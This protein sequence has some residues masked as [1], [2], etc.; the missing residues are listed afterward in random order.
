[1]FRVFP[2]LE[3]F[4]GVPRYMD[5]CDAL[6]LNLQRA[7]PIKK[8]AAGPAFRQEWRRVEAY[9]ARVMDGVRE[10]WVV[11]EVDRR[12]LLRRRP[13]ANVR[14]IPNGIERRWEDAG[15]AAEKAPAALFLGNLTVGHN[16]DAA[17]HFA[18]EVWPRVR[19]AMPEAE[20]HLVGEP[21]PQVRALDGRD[22][23]RVMGYVEDLRPVLA[24][25]VVSVAP[26]RYGAGIQN[27]VLET[28]AAGLPSLLSGMVAEP[29]GAAPGREVV[30]AD[31]D[32]ATAAEIVALLRDPSRAR[33]IGL[34]GQ[35]YVRAR[36][37]WDHAAAR[38]R[39]IAGEMAGS[40]G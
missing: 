26:L 28:M 12:D 25:T 17:M 10:T 30:V 16:V 7:S 1:M 36:F 20:L 21:A 38:F 9:E 22:G 27:K 39:E 24:R 37:T 32:E 11:T 8:G 33:E 3:R 4:G 13:G 19:A 34:A 23:V 5:L 29:L 6:T 31:T 40:H 2:F 14:V 35:A 15:L 18:A